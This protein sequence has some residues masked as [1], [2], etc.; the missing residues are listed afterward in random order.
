MTSK[1]KM[2]SLS[3]AKDRGHSKIEPFGNRVLLERDKVEAEQKIGDSNL[4]VPDVAKE[5]PL[6]ATV[7]AVGEGRVNPDGSIAPIQLE[8]GQK[9]LIGKY[10]GVELTLDRITYLIASPDEVL[11]V[12]TFGLPNKTMSER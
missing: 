10:A 6:T 4:V 12:V 3:L 2:E 11:A 1:A 9:V 5:K 7:L 8:P